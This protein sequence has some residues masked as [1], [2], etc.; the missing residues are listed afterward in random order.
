MA[1]KM[2]KIDIIT[3][4]SKFEELKE[5]MND[6]GITGM[7]VTQVLGCGMQKGITEMYRGVP[8]SINLLPKVKL[9]IVVCEVPVELVV[10]TAKKVLR[11]GEIGDGKIFIYPVENVIKVRTG[12]EGV[13]AL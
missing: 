4:P 10:E 13:R 6:I 9:E 5:A 12:E 11:T 3:R 8:V 1:D 7:T 2:T